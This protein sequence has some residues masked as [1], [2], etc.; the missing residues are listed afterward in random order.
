MSFFQVQ[1]ICKIHIDDT[2]KHISETVLI[3]LPEDCALSV[4][5]LINHNEV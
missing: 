3:E 1:D 4:Q 5:D 2:L